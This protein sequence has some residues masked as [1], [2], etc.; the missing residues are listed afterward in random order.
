[1]QAAC[2]QALELV[3]GA[4]ESIFPE[5]EALILSDGEYA[6]ALKYVAFRKQ[7]E[8]YRSI[9]DFL[10]CELYTE[11]INPCMKFYDEEGAP[12]RELIDVSKRQEYSDGL[13]KALEVALELMKDERRK[14]W[15]WFVEQWQYALAA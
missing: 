3:G 13:V 11:W 15:G 5:A 6:K 14:S 2:R 4:T 10:F 12:L 7:P 8:R 1:M 9:M